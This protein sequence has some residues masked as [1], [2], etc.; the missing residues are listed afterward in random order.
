LR[1]PG[2]IFIAC[3]YYSIGFGSRIECFLIRF[4]KVFCF[5]AVCSLKFPST[6]ELAR[7]TCGFL[8]NYLEFAEEFEKVCF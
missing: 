1:N 7:L 3:I 2:H 5:I 4:K 8:I 6:K